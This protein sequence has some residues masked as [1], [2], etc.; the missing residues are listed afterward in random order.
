MSSRL[1]EEATLGTLFKELAEQTGRLVSDEMRLAR[2]ELKETARGAS[3]N[4]ATVAI[5]GV[6]V[7]LGGMLLVVA[8]TL[9][10]AKLIPLWLSAL[11]IGVLLVAAGG[12]AAMTGV[13]ALRTFDLAPRETVR[14][15]KEDSQWLRAELSR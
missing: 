11:V 1:P 5:G 4:L 13:K 9:L 10:L 3:R 12:V 15:L 7:T 8:C 6:T 2:C 14:T